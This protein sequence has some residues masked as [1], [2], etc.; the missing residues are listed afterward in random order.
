MQR[1][2]LASRPLHSFYQLCSSPQPTALLRWTQKSSA[3]LKQLQVNQVKFL[4]R[5]YYYF[6]L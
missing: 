3:K 5:L 1:G 2:H 4:L 6:K